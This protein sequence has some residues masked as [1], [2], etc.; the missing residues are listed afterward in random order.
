MDLRGAYN[1]VRIK[2]GEEW[3]TVFRTKYG[4]YEYLVMLFGLTNAPATFQAF[5]NNVLKEYLNNFI[6][7]YLDDILIFSK[8][9]DEHRKHV[10]QVLQKLAQAD[11]RVSPEKSEFH[12]QEVD[13][14]GFVIRPNVIKIDKGKINSLKE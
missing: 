10:H 5:I 14:L 7:V 13:F 9:L 8:T 11:L 3:K 12:K 1:L 2:A 4:L 6:A